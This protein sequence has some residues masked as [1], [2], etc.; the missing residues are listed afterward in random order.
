M[1]EFSGFRAIAELWNSSRRIRIAI[2]ASGAYIPITSALEY[3]S[4]RGH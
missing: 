4:I 1:R 2:A 3:N